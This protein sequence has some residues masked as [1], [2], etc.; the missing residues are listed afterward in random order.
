MADA[1]ELLDGAKTGFD[2]VERERD[3]RHHV[4]GGGDFGAPRLAGG[5]VVGVRVARPGRG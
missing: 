1:L 4:A 5:H 3:H 2:L